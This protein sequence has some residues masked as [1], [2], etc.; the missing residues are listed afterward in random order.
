[1]A[2]LDVRRLKVRARVRLVLEL[3]SNYMRHLPTV[4]V[5]PLISTDE[6]KPYLGINPLI[7]LNGRAFAVRL[8]QMAGV[9]ESNL[10]DA[11]CGLSDR[12]FEIATAINR[13]LFY[14]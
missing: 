11:I 9:Q 2:R 1:M 3:Q 8:E 14:V 7:D 4:V 13:L 10:G 5:A 12:E 6:L